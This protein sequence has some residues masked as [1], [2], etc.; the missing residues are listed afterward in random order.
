MVE[1]KFDSTVVSA[2]YGRIAAGLFMLASVILPQFGVDV[3][4][5]DQKVIIDTGTKV[6]D[7]GYQ[8]ASVISGG[9]G[10]VLAFFSKYREARKNK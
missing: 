3:S 7:S 10:V 9:I 4:A 1:N 5:E 6:I 8:F 2:M